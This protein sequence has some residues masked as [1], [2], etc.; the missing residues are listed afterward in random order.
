MLLANARPTFMVILPFV[1]TS[2][3]AKN[4]AVRERESP[5][6]ASRMPEPLVRRMPTERFQESSYNLKF[7]EQPKQVTSNPAW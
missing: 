3:L 6:A 7:P 5:V 1:P 2:S 4:E